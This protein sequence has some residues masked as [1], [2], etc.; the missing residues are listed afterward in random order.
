MKLKFRIEQ[1]MLEKVSPATINRI[2]TFCLVC[3]IKVFRP[4][5]NCRPKEKRS[6]GM[7]FFL[8]LWVNMPLCSAAIGV[9]VLIRLLDKKV[10]S[11][12]IPVITATLRAALS[13]PDDGGHINPMEVEIRFPAKGMTKIVAAIPG[14]AAVSEIIIN[15]S[16]RAEIICQEV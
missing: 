8:K 13:T 9:M 2:I 4:K 10:T 3:R 6:S 11:I 7:R 15:C 5:P 12:T 1:A 16:S 14:I